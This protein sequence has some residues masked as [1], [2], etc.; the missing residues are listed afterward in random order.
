MEIKRNSFPEILTRWRIK[1]RFWSEQECRAVPTQGTVGIVYE[2][3][4]DTAW[5]GF[6]DE[7][8]VP[9]PECC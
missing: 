6:C 2:S 5:D 4:L 1:E 9:F 3:V 7:A 8:L